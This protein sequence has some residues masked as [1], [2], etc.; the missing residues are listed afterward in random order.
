MNLKN[1]SIWG[2]VLAVELVLGSGCGMIRNLDEMHDA[3]NKMPEL[4]GK[5]I[6]GMGTTNAMMS[7]MCAGQGKI[8]TSDYRDKLLNE[9]DKE[10]D[11]GRKLSLA[12]K[13]HFAWEFQ[14]MNMACG[15]SDT[16]LKKVYN[17]SVKEFLE[18]MHRFI[19]TRSATGATS[20]NNDMNTLYA[21]AATMHY[22][23]SLQ[24][25]DAENY[26]YKAVSMLDLLNDVV[27]ASAD[28]KASKIATKD[29]PSYIDSGL[30]LVGDLTYMLQVRY[31]FLT[32]FAFGLSTTNIVGDE[33]TLFG[34]AKYVLDGIFNRAWSPD[35]ANKNTSQINYYSLIMTRALA[36]RDMLS[37]MDVEPATD[38]VIY[39]VFRALNFRF[40]TAPDKADLL[41]VSEKKE[42]VLKFQDLVNNYLTAKN[43]IE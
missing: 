38:G 20:R 41:F 22:V 17:E 11:I 24:E 10:Q 26:G 4:M 31:N 13:Y 36:T 5:T 8:T 6:N 30:I 28:L 19:G 7:E 15:R 32:A 1:T 37:A 34:K 42:A 35:F 21:I 23:N 25:K 16:Y 9:I 3:T 27:N 14:G 43:V 39:K 18:S 2:V 33:A 40:N 29:L 12:V